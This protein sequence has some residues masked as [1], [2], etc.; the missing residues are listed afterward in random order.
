MGKKMTVRLNPS[1]FHDLSHV[2]A[3]DMPVYP[4]EP[5]P[6]FIPHLKLGKD[7]VNVSILHL[8][9]HTGTHV[10]A[11][12]HFLRKGTSIDKIPIERFIGEAVIVDLSHN[13]KRKGIT[14][15]DLDK[16]SDLIQQ[17]D[18]VLI[19]SGASEN[20]QDYNKIKENFAYLEPSAARWIVDHKIKCVGIDSLSMEK[21]GFIEG[22]SH[23]I[24]LGKGIGIIEGLNKN[25][26]HFT[27]KRMFLVSLPLLLKGIDGSPARTVLFD[28]A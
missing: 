12:K 23:K 18:I 21:F 24:L 11:P 4:G 7:K 20:W 27:G 25:L 19:Y 22:T 26:K 17:G 15:S 28:L 13:G 16:Y 14:D 9:S 2:I 3:E 10:D 8:G 5:K 6:E 1:S